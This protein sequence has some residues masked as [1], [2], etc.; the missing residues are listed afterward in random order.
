MFGKAGNDK[1]FGL[2]GND[3]LDGGSGRDVLD[4]GAGNDRIQARDKTRDV[5]RCGAGRDTAVV[6][7]VDQFAACEIVL[8]PRTASAASAASATSTSSA[9]SFRV[10]SIQ[11]DPARPTGCTAQRMDSDRDS[12]L[13]GR[14]SSGSGRE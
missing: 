7:R 11:S 8:R 3:K 5:V 10:E 14:D 1:L 2:A 13:R 12:C 9:A 6:D 4:G